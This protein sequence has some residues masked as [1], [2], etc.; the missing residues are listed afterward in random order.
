MG[1]EWLS[2][3]QVPNALALLCAVIVSAA[4]LFNRKLHPKLCWVLTG[5][6]V[7]FAATV[8]AKNVAY[9]LIVSQPKA[10]N[11]YNALHSY[12]NFMGFVAIIQVIIGL[13]FLVSSPKPKVVDWIANSTAV[14]CLYA[15]TCSLDWRHTYLWHSVDTPM[16]YT[17]VTPVLHWVFVVMFTGFVGMTIYKGIQHRRNNR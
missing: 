7:T 2:G 13:C 14:A 1:I 3:S 8:L 6:S 5:V 10:E 4:M 15:A 17:A 12:A 9:Y 16:H 11:S